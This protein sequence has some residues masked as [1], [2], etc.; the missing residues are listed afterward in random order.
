METDPCV[1]RTIIASLKELRGV[2]PKPGEWYAA[3]FC[4]S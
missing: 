2:K 4:S 3:V 1:K